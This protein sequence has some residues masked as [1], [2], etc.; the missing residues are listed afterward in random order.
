MGRHGGFG[1]RPSKEKR[2]RIP[3]GHRQAK[4]PPWSA[5]GHSGNGKR[6]DNGFLKKNK[7]GNSKN[8]HA[9][10]GSSSKSN[11]KTLGSGAA[12][13]GS[14]D[15]DDAFQ[16]AMETTLNRG[17]ES[18]YFPEGRI[19]FHEATEEST[20]RIGVAATGSSTP[21][22]VRSLQSSSVAVP[23]SAFVSR[24]CAFR[25]LHCI[26]LT[27][28]GCSSFFVAKSIGKLLPISR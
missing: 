24:Q 20:G 9:Q 26:V 15:T 5:A 11:G 18:A 27:P 3:L 7:N 16:D 14:L 17:E 4:K 8:G 22:K 12:V 10:G 28:R 19:R 1:R 13:F 23:A 6:G 25:F 2:A 21:S